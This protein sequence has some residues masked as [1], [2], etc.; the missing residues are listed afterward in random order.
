MTTSQSAIQWT[1][2]IFAKR[3]TET[4]Q[5]S[6][7]VWYKPSYKRYLI[8]M[9][10]PPKRCF[11]LDVTWNCIW[12]MTALGEKNNSNTVNRRKMHV[13]HQELK[14]SYWW[15]STHIVQRVNPIPHQ[16]GSKQLFPKVIAF[17]KKRI[18]PFSN[19]TQCVQFVGTCAQNI[20]TFVDSHGFR[21]L[22][23]LLS[24]SHTGWRESPK[25]LM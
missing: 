8:C 15:K 23:I 25:T 4:D 11:P 21:V 10:Y 9:N 18:N 5:W 13:K 1:R 24:G 16:L 19:R 20:P 3:G 7:S 22:S 2:L 17:Q 14:F 6:T 12:E